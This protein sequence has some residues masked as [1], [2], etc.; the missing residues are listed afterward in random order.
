MKKFS[1]EVLGQQYAVECGT[2]KECNIPI[3]LEGQ[4]YNYQ[5]RIH[6]NTV[7]DQE[8]DETDVEKEGRIKNTVAHEVFHAFCTE[9][10]IY[11]P[12]DIEE[13]LATFY[14]Q[15]WEKLHSVATQILEEM[16]DEI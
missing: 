1:V 9:S 15:Q 2:R 5:K 12:G 7:N 8:P 13:Q 3:E 6:V 14:G 11:L 16:G 4:C 10:G